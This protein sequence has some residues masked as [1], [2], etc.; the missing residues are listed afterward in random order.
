[1]RRLLIRP[2]ALGDFLVSLPALEALRTDYTELWTVAAHL[3]LSGFATRAR[4]LSSTGLDLLELGLAP[5]ELWRHLATF[6]SIVSWYGTTRQEFRHAVRH[7]PF[8]FLPALPEA[9][10][11]LHA[12]EFYARQAESLGVRLERK[13]PRIAVPRVRAMPY[14][15]L[16]PFSGSPRKNWPIERFLA[17]AARLDLPAAFTA[18]PEEELPASV[19]TR[20]FA[21]TGELAAWLGNA[22]YYIGNDS[23]PTHLA[24][25]TGTPTLAI[26]GPTDP[27]VWAPPSALVLHATPGGADPWPTVEQA[28]A[29]LVELRR[30]T[31]ASSSS[32]PLPPP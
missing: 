20:R 5:P 29:A 15:A 6:D 17:L 1:M 26:F 30:C 11:S 9:G 8:T 19:P 2:G 18:G 7:L 14:A 28:L 13:A 31:D 3:P 25:A 10:S 27:E 16:H 4:A 21:G 12:T 22:A 24:A 32:L 23:G